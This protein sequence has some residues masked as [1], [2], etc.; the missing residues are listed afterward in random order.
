M[1]GFTSSRFTFFRFVSPPPRARLP[2]PPLLTSIRPPLHFPALTSGGPTAGCGATVKLH[3]GTPSQA[4]G[5][6]RELETIGRYKAG[7]CH[8]PGSGDRDAARRR[9]PRPATPCPFRDR[10]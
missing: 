8:P 3:R 1:I 4:I 7:L 5:P 2:T 10:P 9:L 6:P